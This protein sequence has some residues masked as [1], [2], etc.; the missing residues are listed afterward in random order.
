[1]WGK[2]LRRGSVYLLIPLS[3]EL[4]S[5]ERVSVPDGIGHLS[6]LC[7]V[8][9]FLLPFFVVSCKRGSQYFIEN[10]VGKAFNE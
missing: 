7:G 10:A 3:Q 9:G 8:D 6:G 1:L 2:A 4:T 5:L